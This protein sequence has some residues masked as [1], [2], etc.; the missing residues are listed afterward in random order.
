[1]KSITDLAKEWEGEMPLEVAERGIA[2]G[3]ECQRALLCRQAKRKFDSEVAEELAR[4]AGT[5]THPFALAVASLWIIDCASGRTLRKLIEL[6]GESLDE[7]WDARPLRRLL[8]VGAKH[9]FGREAQAE[10]AAR[11]VLVSDAERLTMVSDWIMDCD[12]SA[13]LLELVERAHEPVT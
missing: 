6:A 8:C 11:L 1:M 10:L 2:R 3:L 9:K 5:L 7:W 4:W 12:S 13:D